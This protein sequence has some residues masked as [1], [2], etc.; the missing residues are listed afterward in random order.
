MPTGIE[1][2]IF[3]P[4]L[5]AICGGCVEARRRAGLRSRKILGFASLASAIVV[6]I[7]Q[8]EGSALA[9]SPH[10]YPSFTLKI[11]GYDATIFFQPKVGQGGLSTSIFNDRRHE[12]RVNP[13]T[14]ADLQNRVDKAE[15]VQLLYHLE[16]N[17]PG[18]IDLLSK[19]PSLKPFFVL[20]SVQL[21][22]TGAI[23]EAI[24]VKILSTI[25]QLSDDPD[26]SHFDKQGYRLLER[27]VPHFVMQRKLYQRPD[28]RPLSFFRHLV[29]NRVFTLT[30]SFLYGKRARVDYSFRT[31]QVFEEHW[32]DIDKATHDVVPIIITPPDKLP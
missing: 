27:P 24:D 5:R 9:F 10:D 18:A 6:L 14:A 19:I 32:V 20:V 13:S 26:R 11:F 22:P 31:D 16:S 17:G 8:M 3:E 7:T 15:E 21:Q 25:E 23:A 4:P 28:G 30:G 12:N 2:G 1:A 29:S